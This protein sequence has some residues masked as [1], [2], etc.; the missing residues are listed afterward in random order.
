VIDGLLRFA[1]TP[2]DMQQRVPTDLFGGQLLS[3]A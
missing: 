2:P 3:I 1:D